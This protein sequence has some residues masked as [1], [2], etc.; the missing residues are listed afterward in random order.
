[1][2]AALS[3]PLLYLFF[4]VPFG[5]FLTP[6]LQ[7]FTAHFID[8][9]LG[10]LGIPHVVDAY[11]I[12][13]PEGRFVVA[14]ACAGLRFLIASIAFGVLYACLMYR[15]IWRRLGFIAASMVV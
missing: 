13:I 6:V 8:V 11:F 4:L 15:G 5:A 2:F 7:G 10:V 3:A 12:E 14:E 9:G 1:M